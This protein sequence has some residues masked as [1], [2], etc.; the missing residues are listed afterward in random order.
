MKIQSFCATL[1]VDENLY[2]NLP[3]EESL[4]FVKNEVKRYQEFIDSPVISKILGDDTVE[5]SKAKMKGYRG[6]SVSLK[7]TPS[8]ST[9]TFEGG[10]FTNSK[11]V[12]FLRFP[13][14][15]RQTF[16]YIFC[17]LGCPEQFNNFW[18]KAI[19]SKKG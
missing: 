14:L 15:A 13:E 4:D 1:K 5:L 8:D 10:I 2:K 3:D 9:D 17:K 16:Q 18:H 11:D 7:I 19:R 12:K 6:Y